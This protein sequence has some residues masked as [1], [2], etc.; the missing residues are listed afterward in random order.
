MST[1]AQAETAAEATRRDLRA[2]LTDME[3]YLRATASHTGEKIGV[4][5]ERLQEQLGKAK[6]RLAD[7][8]EV[9]V[10]KTKQAA[11]ATDDYV[12]DNPWRAVG[13]AAAAG[14]II[15]LLIGRR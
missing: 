9:V 14:L 4:I 2:V 8:R 6:E 7:T 12:H 3:E 5:R 1:E 13:M 15:G 10:D 11:R